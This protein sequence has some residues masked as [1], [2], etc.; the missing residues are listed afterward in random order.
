MQSI[1]SVMQVAHFLFS[2]LKR[3]FFHQANQMVTDPPAL[4]LWRSHLLTF[5][6]DR[7]FFIHLLNIQNDF[8]G[9]LQ[10]PP[11]NHMYKTRYSQ[12]VPN[13]SPGWAA[14]QATTRRWTP[15]SMSKF[16][17]PSIAQ[18]EISHYQKKDKYLWWKGESVSTW[19]PLFF[20]SHL[21][22]HRKWQNPTKL[23]EISL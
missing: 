1:S 17:I 11:D 15:T 8:S 23:F 13:F 19:V 20:F 12:H 5:L 18:D 2:Y 21:F 6:P 3:P 9:V 4:M 16:P 14:K 7:N 10:S 22:T